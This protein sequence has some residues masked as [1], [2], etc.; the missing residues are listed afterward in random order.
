MEAGSNKWGLWRRCEWKQPCQDPFS[1]ILSN[2]S[3]VTQGNQMRLIR[4]LKLPPYFVT[5]SLKYL[6]FFVHISCN[7]VSFSFPSSNF[8]SSYSIVKPRWL[9]CCCC[10]Y[11]FRK[12]SEPT[13][14]SGLLEWSLDWDQGFSLLLPFFYSLFFLLFFF[15]REC[16]KMPV[17]HNYDWWRMERCQKNLISFVQQIFQVAHLDLK[18][19]TLFGFL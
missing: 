19:T 14:S 7:F 18:K 1:S 10:C 9:K 2:G 17:Y 11:P 6:Y 4:A 8:L 15:L 13:S 5:V 12:T 3:K 16:D